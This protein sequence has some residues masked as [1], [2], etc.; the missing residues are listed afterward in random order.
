ML[1][2]RLD[3]INQSSEALLTHINL[4][5]WFGEWLFYLLERRIMKTFR[6]LQI[7]VKR[8]W[9]LRAQSFSKAIS[10]QSQ[11]TEDVH[12]YSGQAMEE[13][14]VRDGQKLF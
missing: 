12:V 11:Q 3:T 7:N 1:F 13:W 2:I 6:F 4:D 14:I 5:I 8:N 9:I 10:E